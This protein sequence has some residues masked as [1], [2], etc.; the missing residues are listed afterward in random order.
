[1]DVQVTSL[2]SASQGWTTLHSFNDT[3]EQFVGTL[4]DATDASNVIASGSAGTIGPS[5]Q[6]AVRGQTLAGPTKGLHALLSLH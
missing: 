4:A 3:M 5:F 2:L 6:E 1:M